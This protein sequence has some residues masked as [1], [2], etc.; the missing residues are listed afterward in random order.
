VDSG[1][2]AVVTFDGLTGRQ[3]SETEILGD[4]RRF[5]PG[6]IGYGHLH[7][8]P[9][10]LAFLCGGGIA[11]YFILRDPRDVAVSHVHYVTEMKPDHILHRYYQERLHSF[12][13]RLIASIRG[14]TNKELGIAMGKPTQASLPA[15][16][17]RFEPYL[18]WLERPEVMVLRYEDFIGG[19]EQALEGVLD[20]AVER[21]F[22]LSISRA[23]AI[24]VL[25]Q[26][27]DPQ[28][29]PTFR[30]GKIGSWQ[31]AFTE[32]HKRAFKDSA[33][34]LLLLLGYE[35]NLDW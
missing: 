21:G 24:Q 4:L 31:A 13:Q 19:R 3:R 10:I 14:V 1:L 27:I 17:R 32:D 25:E 26:N 23:S 9:E 28:R 20:H 6:D 30:S 12:D 18:G 11:V 5:L 2:P 34:D 22:K 8:S 33:G 29:S 35:I 15:I 7:A 16:R